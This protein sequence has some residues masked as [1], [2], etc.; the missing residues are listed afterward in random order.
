MRA[1]I[2]SALALSV[3]AAPAFAQWPAPLKAALDRSNSGAIYVFEITHN[4]SRDNAD[5]GEV[6]TETAYARVDF[7]KEEFKQ[8]TP[9]H[10]YD[11]SLP[12]SS[13]GALAA[14][15]NQIED[16]IWCTRFGENI[17]D[18]V[19]VLKETSRTIT[20][21]FTPKIPE[22]AGGPEKKIAKRMRA[23]IT[24]SK[25][26]P[27][28]LAYSAKLSKPV[29]LFVV[30]KIKKI[31]QAVT[32]ERAPDGRTYAARF[33]NAYDGAGGGQSG[34]NNG[35]TNVTALYDTSGTLIAQLTN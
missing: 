11:D 14:L 13:F 35:E 23:E 31:E 4:S 20:Y 27:A 6:E 25:N 29:T 12:G 18:K 24:V 5:T 33:T 9:A 1:T 2:L 8:I 28:V 34:G 19:E 32:C 17:P 21:G 10:L 22:D 16:G 30:F 15:E 3:S 7:S 26:D